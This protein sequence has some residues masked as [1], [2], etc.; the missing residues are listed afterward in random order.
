MIMLKVI[1]TLRW[2]LQIHPASGSQLIINSRCR[3]GHICSVAFSKAKEV[4]RGVPPPPHAGSG[5]FI[6]TSA[7]TRPVSSNVASKNPFG[8]N[9]AK[10]R[11]DVLIAEHSA[12]LS[13]TSEPVMNGGC[14][15]HDTQAED[16]QC[17]WATEVINHAAPA[18]SWL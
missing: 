8:R 11:E 7:T 14:P 5:G 6:L 18:R 13:M 17:L 12:G 3:E 2:R 9:V 4:W 10:G 16:H 15:T 1:V